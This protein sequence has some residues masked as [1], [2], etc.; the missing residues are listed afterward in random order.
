MVIMSW[1]CKNVYLKPVICLDPLFRNPKKGIQ[2]TRIISSFGPL[3]K[4][5][6]I[7]NKLT[8]LANGGAK[9]LPLRR[10]ENHQNKQLNWPKG[11]R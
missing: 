5:L 3:E 1:V 10:G 9:S 2:T 8:Q 7:A 4:I 6:L 11:T